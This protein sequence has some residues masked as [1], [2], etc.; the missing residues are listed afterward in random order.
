MNPK[1]TSARAKWGTP[2]GVGDNVYLPER[3]SATS[4]SKSG[5]YFVENGQFIWLYV[6]PLA[7]LTFVV[8]L[9][10]KQLP[11]DE[12]HLWHPRVAAIL[13]QIRKDKPCGHP[14]LPLRVVVPG[15][16]EEGIL[17]S[18]VTVEDRVGSTGGYSDFV[19]D[20]HNEVVARL[21]DM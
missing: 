4:F 16:S 15:T 17:H 13:Q 8:E 6:D 21:R 1:G 2:T 12:I 19:V 18:V 20:L 9:F 14:Y 10:G 3:I 11:S 5:I 7:D